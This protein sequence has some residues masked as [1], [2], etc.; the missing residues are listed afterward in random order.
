MQAWKTEISITFILVL[1]A[2]ALP[3]GCGG[4]TQGGGKGAVP[5]IKGQAGAEAAPGEGKS[6]GEEMTAASMFACE[7]SDDCSDKM[8]CVDGECMVPKMVGRTSK[9][10]Q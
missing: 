2:C 1:A 3:M 10:G 9:S 7:S 5:S 8:I 4:G 6:E